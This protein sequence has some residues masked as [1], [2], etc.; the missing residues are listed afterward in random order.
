M[1]E[2][3]CIVSRTNGGKDTLA[4]K[5][6]NRLG[7]ESVVSYTTRPMRHYEVDG[8]HH[9]FVTKE[10]MKW[11]LENQ[12]V[13]AYTINDETGIEYCATIESLPNDKHVYIINPDGINWL[14]NN[15]SEEE[16]KIY[17][18]EL[19]APDE[20]LRQRAIER[21]DDIEVFEK[22]LSSETKEFLDFHNAEISNVCIDAT[23]EPEMIYE[24]FLIDYTSWCNK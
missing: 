8:V 1:K 11:I 13:I 3:I 23:M 2:L 24:T 17:V 21:G 12:T 6:H 4:K 7:I 18:V 19:W 14:K 10:Y 22:R 16:C 15:V 5:I 20:V 9:K